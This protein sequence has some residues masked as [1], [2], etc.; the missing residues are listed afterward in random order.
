MM[1]NCLSIVGIRDITRSHITGMYDASKPRGNR[2][3][4]VIM[5]VH[6]DTHP[7][8]FQ[9]IL[10]PKNIHKVETETP[11]AKSKQY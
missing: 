10:N 4:L 7:E 5:S 11:Q 8:S 6:E 3:V 1:Q 9:T 2:S